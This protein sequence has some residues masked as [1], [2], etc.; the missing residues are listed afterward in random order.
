MR[1]TLPSY[2]TWRVD[3]KADPQTLLPSSYERGTWHGYI[4]LGPARYRCQ[5]IGETAAL[6]HKNSRPAA[7]RIRIRPADPLRPNMPEYVLEIVGVA[8]EALSC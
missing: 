2:L 1:T 6:L 5:A 4:I 8:G 3:C 7:I